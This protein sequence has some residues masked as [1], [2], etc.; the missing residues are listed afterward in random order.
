MPAASPLPALRDWRAW[1]D[2]ARAMAASPAGQ[3]FSPM[4]GDS[5]NRVT[6]PLDIIIVAPGAMRSAGLLPLQ[7]AP[8]PAASCSIEVLDAALA[9]VNVDDPIE[10]I[11]EGGKALCTNHSLLSRP[12]AWSINRP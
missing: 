6:E 5:H 2:S 1:R 3:S 4:W 11:V 8:E 12:G 10:P 7:R 9:K